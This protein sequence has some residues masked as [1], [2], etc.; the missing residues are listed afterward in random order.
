MI[1]DTSSTGSSMRSSSSNGRGGARLWTGVAGC[2][3]SEVHVWWVWGMVAGC[4]LI[5][6][7]ADAEGHAVLSSTALHLGF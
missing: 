3:L 2:K 7:H 1:T 5:G 6:V 4:M